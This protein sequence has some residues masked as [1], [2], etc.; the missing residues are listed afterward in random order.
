MM[1]FSTELTSF[2]FFIN[3]KTLSKG[4]SP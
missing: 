1:S 3:F 4:W 2:S